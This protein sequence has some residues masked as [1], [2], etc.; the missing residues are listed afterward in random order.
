MPDRADRHPTQVCFT[1]GQW[2]E[3][4]LEF[5]PDELVATFSN[6]TE[7]ALPA[8]AVELLDRYIAKCE[9]V[10]LAA[11][12]AGDIARRDEYDA[13]RRQWLNAL[14]RIEYRID[15]NQRLRAN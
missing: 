11:H 13:Y 9:H 14:V 2:R 7:V 10:M 6:S 12:A 8:L 4:A 15:R 3:E 1:R 5:H